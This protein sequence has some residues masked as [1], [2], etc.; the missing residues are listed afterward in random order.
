MDYLEFSQDSE[1]EEISQLL[2]T[3]EP[4][5]EFTSPTLLSK[6]LATQKP[7]EIPKI[8]CLRSLNAFLFKSQRKK[9]NVKT[10]FLRAHKKATRL[11]LLDKSLKRSVD[12][13]NDLTVAQKMA[14]EC[15]CSFNTLNKH[16]MSDA[17]QTDTGPRSDGVA[18]RK[19]KSNPVSNNT[20]ETPDCSAMSIPKSFNDE[21]L[22]KYFSIQTIAESFRR[23]IE[24]AFAEINCNELAQK[25]K[26]KCCRS[27][28]H[29]ALCS[30]RWLML[31][32]E[33]KTEF[34]SAYAI[35]EI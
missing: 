23:Y 1:S 28:Q 27:H 9:A 29:L 20:I 2:F 6:L 21:F 19:S 15:F 17:S 33:L 22:C 34:I 26:F 13:S 12:F 4:R 25:F 11:S 8:K 14:W 7:H 3:H 24:F 32:A 30:E 16:V 31:K 5:E 10:Y 35:L 18:R